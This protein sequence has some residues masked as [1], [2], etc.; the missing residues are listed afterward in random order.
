MPNCLFCRIARGEIPCSKV[1]ENERVLA[2]RD[3]H[4]QAPTH[5]LVIPKLHISTLYDTVDSQ[6]DLLGELLLVGQ[7]L[8]QACENGGQ[9]ARFLINCRQ[10]GGQEVDHL[11]LHVLAGRPLGPMLSKG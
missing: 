3:I 7:R 5:L 11:H 6:R 9:G 8:A 10:W 4:P 1:F 2:F